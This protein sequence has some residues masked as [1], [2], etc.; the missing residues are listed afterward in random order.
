MIQP[1]VVVLPRVYPIGRLDKLGSVG[2]ADPR[3]LRARVGELITGSRNYVSGDSWQHIHWR[4][5]ARTV[6]P[7]IKDFEKSTDD[8]VVRDFDATRV[9]SDDGDA[10]EDAIR[11]AAS[12]GDFVCRQSRT[13]RLI[14]GDL[15]EETSDRYRILHALA[16][17]EDVQEPTLPSL[18]QGLPPYSDVLA[19]VRGGD[20]R[21]VEAL[22]QMAR[23][24]HRVTAVVMRGYELGAAA[25]DPLD[26]LLRAGVAAV[27]C[28][29]GDLPGALATLGAAK[30]PSEHST[31]AGVNRKT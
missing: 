11:V 25:A 12:V 30:G 13:V 8:S 18:V 3:P 10:M 31:T 1:G 5:T 24:H 9:Q 20:V 7:Q 2:I 19:I 26:E 6:Q 16:L 21:G 15:F 27:E 4:N 14:A 22:S 23:S 29:R 28:W 17:L